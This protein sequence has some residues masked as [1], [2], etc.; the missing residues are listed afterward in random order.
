MQYQDGSW[1]SLCWSEVGHRVARHAQALS[2]MGLKAGDRIG[3][4]L[5]NCVD[6]IVSD[7]AALSQG[8]VTVPLYIRDSSANICHVIRD[9]GAKLVVTDSSERWKAC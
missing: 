3:I 4:L 8:L 6:W 5:P 1:Q 9:S 7:I 2:N